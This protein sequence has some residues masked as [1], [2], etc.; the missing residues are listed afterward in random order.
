MVRAVHMVSRSDTDLLNM[1]QTRYPDGLPVG[2]KDRSHQQMGWRVLWAE[3]VW[4]KNKLPVLE[5]LSLKCLLYIQLEILN[6]L[7]PYVNLDF[8]SEIWAET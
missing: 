7:S 3:K 5:M 1:E 4:G 8:R 6:T 2:V